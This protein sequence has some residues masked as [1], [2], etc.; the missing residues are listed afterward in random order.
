MIEPITDGSTSFQ[1][2]VVSSAPRRRNVATAATFCSNTPTRFV[3]FATF[4]G[5]P[6]KMRIGKV[7]SEPLP[8]SVLMKPA[9]SPV[10]GTAASNRVF[11]SMSLR[12]SG[13]T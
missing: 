9:M 6:N 5:N 7:I 8:A 10:T 1:A 12:N 4:A 2:P 11:L 13:C 3:P